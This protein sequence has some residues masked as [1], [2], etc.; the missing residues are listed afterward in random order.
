[1]SLP[2]QH[3]AA[4]TGWNNFRPVHPYALS[5]PTKLLR[6]KRRPDREVGIGVND[7]ASRHQSARQIH[8]GA[9]N[10]VPR[11]VIDN[12]R[13]ASGIHHPTQHY[14]YVI[15]RKVVHEQIRG[16]EVKV[17]LDLPSHGIKAGDAGIGSGLSGMG[18]GDAEH[19]VTHVRE[20]HAQI[21][22]VGPCQLPDAK[23]DPATPGGDVE[24]TA[25]RSGSDETAQHAPGSPRGKG[26]GIEPVQT[27]ECP[28]DFMQ[29]QQ[30]GIHQFFGLHATRKVHGRE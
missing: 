18:A 11:K 5:D 24:Q 7:G 20:R 1:M 14:T 23:G 8:C 9:R 28:P 19:V 21:D 25:R 22:A 30:G 4:G 13:N 15:V 12:D 6:G 27:L 16:D 26:Q 29:G 2:H 17:A 10:G 3:E